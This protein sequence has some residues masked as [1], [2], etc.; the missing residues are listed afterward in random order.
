MPVLLLAL[1]L[2]SPLESQPFHL[3]AYHGKERTIRRLSLR[4]PADYGRPRTRSLEIGAYIFPA[5]RA[6][7]A[8]PIV[9]LMGGPGIAATLLAPIPP[10]FDLFE[11][12]SE[13]SD[14]VVLDQRGLGVSV[15]RVDCP[16]PASPLP[17]DTFESR[18]KLLAAFETVNS[19]CVAHWRKASVEPGDFSIEQIADDVES[20]RA[21]LNVERVDLLAFSYGTRIASEVLRRHP[22]IVRKAVLQGVLAS[23][24]RMPDADDRTFRAI[25]ALVREQAAAK[26]LDANLEQSLRTF[27]SRLSQAPAKVTVHSVSGQEVRLSVGREAFDALVATR[28][29]DRRLPAMLTSA[30]RG[31]TT[32]LAQWI[33][34][35]LQ[36]LE[37]GSAPLMRAAV[38]CSAAEDRRTAEAARRQGARSLLGEPFDNLQQS[39]PYCRALGLPGRPA[40]APRLRVTTPVL[41]ISGS[42]DDR[43]PPFRA[44]AAR[45]SFA[46]SEHVIVRNGGH[47]L[48]P[49]PKV[50]DVVVAFLRDR[51]V[52]GSPI[53]LD[54]PEFPDVD[55]A[56]RPP[57]RG[58]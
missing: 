12:L 24:I 16:P 39:E 8:P 49:E 42:L 50:Q 1:A 40:R 38:V 21:A 19:A 44:E 35:L 54:T 52:T 18:A 45:K 11:R 51:P 58:R 27:Q 3:K 9:F 6:P 48:L 14:V 25:A 55:A 13:D 29:G 43:T 32:I 34:G 36:D 46:V 30:N 37:K 2:L 23:T 57:Q 22:Q 31:D 41:M 10:Y 56:N 15:P 4:V 17:P 53:E 20:L 5:K 7:S 26:K 33:E 28:L 47:E